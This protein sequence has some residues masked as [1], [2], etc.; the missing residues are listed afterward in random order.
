M[1]EQVAVHMGEAHYYP[2]FENPIYLAAKKEELRRE[3]LFRVK[4]GNFQG[5][6]PLIKDI[7]L[8]KSEVAKIL[9]CW[10]MNGYQG[11]IGLY[12]Y[13]LVANDMQAVLEADKYL[14][15]L[16]EEETKKL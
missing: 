3:N 5:L 13:A 10:N 2:N 12:S 14:A 16:M 6:Y 15:G 1:K 4:C 7:E 8:S 11:L 9:S